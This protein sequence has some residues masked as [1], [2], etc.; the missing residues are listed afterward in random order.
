M[1]RHPRHVARA[2]LLSMRPRQWT[3]NLLL[4]APLIFAARFTDPTAIG[5]ALAGFGLFCLIS[6]AVYLVNDVRDIE[7]DRLHEGK[8]GRPIA[9]GIVSAKAAA[10]VA[11]ALAVP[12]LAGSFALSSQFGL[13]ASAYLGLQL[14]YTFLL[15]ERVILDVM[16]ISAGFVLR[17]VAG[18]FA[19]DVVFSP[20]LLVCT[21]LLALFLA[22]GKRRHELVQSEAG[23]ARHRR[24]PTDYSPQLIDQLTS[25]VTSATIVTYA[26]YTFFSPTS[27]RHQY[28]MLTVPF[29]V[30]GLFRYLYLVHQ[31]H[32]G[33]NPE[34]IL[35][36]DMPLI[37]D[38]VL[39]LAVAV[40]AVSI[41]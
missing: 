36:S 20:W 41:K 12:A 6:G 13:A 40:A 3:K 27:Q 18:A 8:R 17:A 2:V 7:S 10:G 24:S 4:F 14:V 32:L 28:L 29:V 23:A 33:G 39:F 21:A 37:V 34:E 9:S 19:I 26:L 25:A 16:A 15:K 1:G 22:L 5:R 35:L 38:I 11:I 31:K 30:Y